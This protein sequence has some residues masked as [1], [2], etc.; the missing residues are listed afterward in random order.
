MQAYRY[1][2]VAV[3]ELNGLYRELHSGDI[4]FISNSSEF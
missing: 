1:I 3:A 2:L 4:T